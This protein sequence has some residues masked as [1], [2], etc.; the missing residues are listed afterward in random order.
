[1]LALLRVSLLIVGA[2]GILSEAKAE[3][4]PAETAAFVSF[5]NADF[6]SCRS[7]IINIDNMMR[8]GAGGNHKCSFPRS[9][10]TNGSSTLHDD[11]IAATNAILVWLR[12]NAPSRL[13]KAEDAIEQA[14][15]AL[16]PALC[17]P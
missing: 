16:W 14:K 6:E 8:L 5:C 7:W 10:S 4:P 11:S 13:P 9:A 2:L 15:K 1:M 17:K 3:T 12:A